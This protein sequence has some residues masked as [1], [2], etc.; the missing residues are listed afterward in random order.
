MLYVWDPYRI[1]VSKG[2]Q[3]SSLQPNQDHPRTNSIQSVRGHSS[4]FWQVKCPN[5][6]SKT[7]LVSFSVAIIII[8]YMPRDTAKWHTLCSLV[9]RT[10]LHLVNLLCKARLVSQLRVEKIYEIYNSGESLPD[11]V[12]FLGSRTSPPCFTLQNHMGLY[13][14]IL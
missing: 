2:L 4:L 1:Q 9:T 10:I 13:Y 8:F 14:G 5:L 11:L 6:I 7:I 3:D 12:S